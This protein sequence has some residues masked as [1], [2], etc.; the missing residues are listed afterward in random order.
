MA[1][2]ANPVVPVND[3]NEQDPSEDAALIV[4]EDNTQGI[5]KQG[6]ADMQTAIY[7]HASRI[8]PRLTRQDKIMDLIEERIFQKDMLEALPSKELVKLLELLMNSQA[9]SA[10]FLERLYKMTIQA[11]EV[12]LLSLTESYAASGEITERS[13]ARLK[14]DPERKSL[15]L[16]V[17]EHNLLGDQPEDGD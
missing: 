11:K 3:G 17:I 1:K 13:A 8:K 4:E 5:I 9:Q 12:E 15:L 7:E 14:I 10:G 2:K 16:K 6:L